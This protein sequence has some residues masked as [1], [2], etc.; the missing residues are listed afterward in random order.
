MAKRSDGV[1][2]R[3]KLLQTAAAVFARCGYREATVADIC[4]E[5]GANIASVNYYFGSKDELYAE[6]WRY[7]F[8][9]SIEQY[10]PDGRVPPEASARDRLRGQ[11]TALVLRILDPASLDFDIAHREMSNPTGLLAQVMHES[12][13]PL[14]WQMIGVVRELLGEQA[15]ERE[16]DLCCFSAM[17]QCMECARHMR[18]MRNYPLPEGAQKL[19]KS[20]LVN[21]DA[22]TMAEHIYRF[23]LAGI[24]A[25]RQALA[26]RTEKE[27][28]G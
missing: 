26:T 8:Q 20:P 25:V 4:R 3:Q 28:A 15:G 11:I 14:R 10:P 5:A 1:N 18:L 12:L 2:T 9:K 19:P 7:V 13:E 22:E 6:A 17:S 21:A 16:I 24:D 23:S 27:R